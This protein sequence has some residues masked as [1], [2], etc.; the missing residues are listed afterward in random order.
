M[1]LTGCAGYGGGGYYGDVV[2]AEPDQYLFGGDYDRERDTHNYSHRGS[3][4]RQVAH[5]NASR[6]AAHS[7]GSH[8]ATHSSSGQGGRR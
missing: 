3:E 4:S 1:I 5:P 8:E 2:V 7:G 6:G